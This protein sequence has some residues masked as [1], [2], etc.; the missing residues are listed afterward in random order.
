MK[1][2]L[3]AVGCIPLLCCGLDFIRRV[4]VRVA[5]ANYHVT[6]EPKIAASVI[7]I[8]AEVYLSHR[9]FS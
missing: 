5:R 1:A 4:R 9:D 7:R 6:S 3:F 2:A 8:V